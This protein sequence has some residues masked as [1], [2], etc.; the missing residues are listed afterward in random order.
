M[1]KC[2]KCKK[3][4]KKSDMASKRLCK[5]CYLD[6]NAYDNI[7]P[8]IQ[9]TDVKGKCTVCNEEYEMSILLNNGKCLLHYYYEEPEKCIKCRDCGD[10]TCNVGL[11][12]HCAKCFSKL[13]PLSKLEKKAK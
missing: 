2:S 1:T 10:W 8:E 12:N 3:N 6:V 13:K 4:F 9:N 5:T 7:L 11:Y